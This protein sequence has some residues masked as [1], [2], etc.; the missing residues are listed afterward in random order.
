MTG[1][2]NTKKGALTTPPSGNNTVDMSSADFDIVAWCGQERRP[3][4]P[5]GRHARS[6]LLRE[7]MAAD[8]ARHGRRPID[9]NADDE[10]WGPARKYHFSDG[11][12]TIEW[13]NGLWAST[14]G[15]FRSTC[16]PANSRRLRFGDHMRQSRNDRGRPF[17][18]YSGRNLKPHQLVLATHGP[19]PP[20]GKTLVCHHNDIFT[21]NRL[22]NLYWGDKRDNGHDR[23]RNKANPPAAPAPRLPTGTDL[24]IILQFPP[25]TDAEYRNLHRLLGYTREQIDLALESH[26]EDVTQMGTGPLVRWVDC[27]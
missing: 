27:Q 5:E 22:E 14:C 21:D 24:A 23:Y 4:T 20:P 1:T 10:I 17:I 9:I 6:E 19:T 2:T 13:F 18:R 7:L 8:C 3:E 12:M 15:R 11:G 16:D 26:A 25:G